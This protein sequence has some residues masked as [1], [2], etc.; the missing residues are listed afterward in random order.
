MTDQTQLFQDAAPIQVVDVGASAIEDEPAYKDL[1]ATGLANVT[2]FEP[3]PEQ[4]DVLKGMESD[5]ARYLPYALGDG[6]QQEL[7]ICR[8]PGMTSLYEPD[9]DL[10]CHFHGFE[11]WAVV[12]ERLLL[13]THRLDDITEIESVDFI[14][15]DAQGAEYQIIHNGRT[16]ISDAVVL[17]A[18]LSFRPIYKG[19]RPYADV[20]TLLR[21]LGLQV[22]MFSKV[23][24]RAFR[25][26]IFNNSKFEGLHHILQVDVVFI[27][28][29]TLLAD[30]SPQQLLKM[31]AI[32]HYC[33]GSVDAA[34]LALRH[35]DEQSGTGFATQS[36][37]SLS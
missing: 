13:E 29:V 9:M 1:L 27:K 24:R 8:A 7:K 36:A 28:D 33:Y 34:M 15:I 5:T 32:L 2:G 12:E 10:L 22:H 21:E 31:A 23:N 16:K 11:D 6:T 26:L 35:Y 30:L 20:E 14:K 17:E 4:Y 3:S 19:E 18:E 25:P 37:Q